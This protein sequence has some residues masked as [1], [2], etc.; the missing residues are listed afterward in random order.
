M[1]YD[2]SAAVQ[3]SAQASL[4][5]DEWDFTSL[6]IKQPPLW[7][8]N[9]WLNYEYA[10]SCLPLVTAVVELRQRTVEERECGS[11]PPS[12]KHPRH[13]VYLAANY[14]EFPRTPW[15]KLPTARRDMQK[16]AVDQIG[17]PFE[18]NALEVVDTF[19]FIHRIAT[20]DLWLD[21]Q[22]QADQKYS[23][24]KIDFP[25]EEKLI[26]KK[27]GL[28]LARR[29]REYFQAKTAAAMPPKQTKEV[30]SGQKENKRNYVTAFKQLAALRLLEHHNYDYKKCVENTTEHPGDKPLYN[31]LNNARWFDAAKQATERLVRFN[32]MWTVQ[33]EPAYFYKSH[34]FQEVLKFYPKLEADLANARSNITRIALLEKLFCG[35]QKRPE[36]CQTG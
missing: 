13:A 24:F 5:A 8:W 35:H 1:S 12:P 14:P 4:P 32:M 25:R 7:Q 26:I 30:H 10:R 23:F 11:W 21:E 3:A 28:W 15:L 27:F 6:R 29:R 18:E 22:N 33:R 20:G 16:S 19:D 17:G 2:Y 34:E 36:I 9:D 31:D